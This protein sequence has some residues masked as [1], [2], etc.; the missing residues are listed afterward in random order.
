MVLCVRGG[1]ER[2]TYPD[3]GDSL[4]DVF[5]ADGLVF[6]VL[7]HFGHPLLIICQTYYWSVWIVAIVVER[8]GVWLFSPLLPPEQGVCV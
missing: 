8:V 2:L 1:V 7:R 4:D 3:N 6:G 5:E